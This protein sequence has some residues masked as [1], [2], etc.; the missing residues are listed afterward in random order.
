MDFKIIH[1]EQTDSTNR[2]LRR[3]E[4]KD[5]GIMGLTETDDPEILKSLEL[6]RP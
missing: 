5:S 4:S 2:W 1:I 6:N 3:L